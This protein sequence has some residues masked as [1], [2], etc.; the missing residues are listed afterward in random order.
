MTTITFV[1]KDHFC[2]RSVA[3]RVATALP[4]ISFHSLIPKIVISVQPRMEPIFSVKL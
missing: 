4:E 2:S 3:R 1:I